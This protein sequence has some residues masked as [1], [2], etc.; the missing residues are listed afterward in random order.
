MKGIITA[1]HEND[2]LYPIS[3]HINKYLVPVY[4]K[5]MLYYPISTLLQFG[6]KDILIIVNASDND[7]IKSIYGDGSILGINIE[8]IIKTEDMI[9]TRDYLYLAKIFIKKDDVILLNGYSIFYLKQF[10]K[11]INN[12][13][14]IA[15]THYVGK[16]K[17]GIVIDED[18]G[19]IRLSYSKNI[20]DRTVL[21]GLYFYKNRHLNAMLDYKSNL[22]FNSYCINSDKLVLQELSNNIVWFDVNTCEELHDVSSYIKI[23]EK[24]RGKL[25]SSPEYIAYKLGY[26]SKL[27]LQNMAKILRNTFYGKML[28]KEINSIQQ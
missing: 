15:Y 23:I 18:N 13:K 17:D 24:R 1:T 27:E 14:S 28:L 4:S 25:V 16:S 26:I 19:H 2:E 21:T 8:Y 3:Q 7:D 20:S 5:P 10:I 22:E 12:E 9:D 11:D 6:V